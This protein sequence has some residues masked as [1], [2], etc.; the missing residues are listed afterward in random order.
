LRKEEEGAVLLFCPFFGGG[1]GPVMAGSLFD[2]AAEEVATEDFFWSCSVSFLGT[3]FVG[4]VSL[5]SFLDGTVLL[6]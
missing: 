1:D 5:V 2:A 4:I 6:V 3:F